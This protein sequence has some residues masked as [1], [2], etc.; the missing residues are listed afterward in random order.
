MDKSFIYDLEGFRTLAYVPC[1]AEGMVIGNSGV[2]IGAGVDLGQTSADELLA[3]GIAEDVVNSLHE[4][5]GLRGVDAI[6]ALHRAGDVEIPEAAAE[7]ITS[8]KHQQIINMLEKCIPTKFENYPEAV[9]TVLA[10]LAIQYGPALQ[11]RMPKF[12]AALIAF[13]VPAMI[14]ELRNFGDAFPTRRNKEADLLDSD[15]AGIIE[16]MV[17]IKC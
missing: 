1:D 4:F 3:A 8:A 16:A 14:A 17:A 15:K 10:S 2:T 13:D 9:Q 11:S 12:Y 7:A 5:F 6:L